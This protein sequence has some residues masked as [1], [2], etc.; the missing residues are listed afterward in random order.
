MSL[1]V[2]PPRIERGDV[3]L[4]AGMASAGGGHE[5]TYCFQIESPE[6]LRTDWRERFY[7]REPDGTRVH[8]E[9]IPLG[10]RLPRGARALP[11]DRAGASVGAPGA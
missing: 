2:W 6:F 3:V 7:W 8:I 11:V 9:D 10:R 4:N 5:S 1:V